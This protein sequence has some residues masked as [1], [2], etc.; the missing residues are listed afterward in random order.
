MAGGVSPFYS[1]SKLRSFPPLLLSRFFS[2]LVQHHPPPQFDRSGGSSRDAPFKISSL[3]SLADPT[4]MSLHH[5]REEVRKWSRTTEDLPN[6]DENEKRV[7]ASLELQQHFLRQGEYL[8][9]FELSK[10]C[11][12]QEKRNYLRQ[13][14]AAGI[15][16]RG[17][18][19]IREG[20]SSPRLFSP[21]SPPSYRQRASRPVSFGHDTSILEALVEVLRSSGVVDHFYPYKYWSYKSRIM[22]EHE[23]Q[24]RFAAVSSLAFDD[25]HLFHQAMKRAT[26][27][28]LPVWR[29]LQHFLPT[30]KVVDSPHMLEVCNREVEKA[31]FVAFD[32]ERD[33]NAG[34]TTPQKPIDTVQLSL[35]YACYVVDVTTLKDDAISMLSD[36]FKH[37]CVIKIGFSVKS[38]L[39]MLSQSCD[40]KSGYFSEAN[41]ILDLQLAFKKMLPGFS[42][43]SL[44]SL[45]AFAFALRLTKS[46]TTSN[47]ARRPLSHSQLIYAAL[48]SYLLLPLLVEMYDVT[49]RLEGNHLLVPGLSAKPAA[50]RINRVGQYFR[51]ESFSSEEQ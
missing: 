44:R 5:L 6:L 34:P 47:W 32:V 4:Q 2:S 11:E 46:Q 41:S 51:W 23:L 13:I 21:H 26:N 49:Q 42:N 14:L 16:S 33:P 43:I 35:P 3:S 27:A 30:V 45:T 38:D 9:A 19:L 29:G 12:R 28:D 31:G 36:L 25:W 8:H 50:N 10:A 15:G 40:R 37:Q 17:E 22:I 48:D 20:F 1:L 39:F 7:A 24:L 18:K